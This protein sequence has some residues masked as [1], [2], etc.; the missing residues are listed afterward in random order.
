MESTS[1]VTQDSFIRSP[2]FYSKWFDANNQRKI[3]W[4]KIDWHNLPKKDFFSK[5]FSSQ[6]KEQI[7]KPKIIQSEQNVKKFII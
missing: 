2:K 4:P 6:S 1:F 5:L 3:F 7:I